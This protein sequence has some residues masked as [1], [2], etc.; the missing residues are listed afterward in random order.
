M[1]ADEQHGA[2]VTRGENL[3]KIPIL[4]NPKVIMDV[5]AGVRRWLSVDVL[6][7]RF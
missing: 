4:K 2:W 1:T 3:L 5:R 6:E 7:F